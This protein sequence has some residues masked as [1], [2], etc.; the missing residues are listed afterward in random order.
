MELI[1]YDTK[2]CS[3]L[4][5]ISCYPITE[6]TTIKTSYL[7][8]FCHICVSVTLWLEVIILLNVQIKVHSMV[9]IAASVLDLDTTQFIDVTII[10]QEGHN[11]KA[12]KDDNPCYTP[13]LVIIL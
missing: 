10:K 4:L 7:L 1:C 5:F 2:Q 11:F 12:L 8:M 13:A 9:I 3:L 6:F